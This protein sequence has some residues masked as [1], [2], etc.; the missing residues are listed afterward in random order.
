MEISGSL[1]G[2]FRVPPATTATVN[3]QWQVGQLLQATVTGSEPG[4]ALLAIGN[5]QVV[6]ETSLALQKGQQLTMLIRSLGSQPVLQITATQRESELV[7]AVRMLLPRQAGTPP[8]LASIGQLARSTSTMVPPNISELSRILLRQLPDPVSISSP[9]GLKQAL[10]ESGLFLENRLLQANGQ[11]SNPVSLNTDFKANLLRL[12]QVVRDWPGTKRDMA[13]V[14]RQATGNSNTTAGPPAAEPGKVPGNP[15]VTPEQAR[16]LMRTGVTPPATARATVTTPQNTGTPK[17]PAATNGTTV[18]S[19]TGSADRIPPPFRG[20]VPVP[21]SPVQPN[22]DLLNPDRMRT[23]FLRQ[24]EATLSRLQLQQLATVPREGE[25]SLVEWLLELPVRRGEEFDLWSMRWYQEPETPSHPASEQNGWSVQL[26][27]DLPG[28][29]PMQALV[30]LHGEQ[31]TTRFWTQ[32]ENTMPLLRA[33]LD[34]L[35]Q[36][37]RAAGLEVGKLDCHTGSLPATATAAESE[38]PLIREKA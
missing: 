33:N 6:A 8:L 1:A 21:Q 38:K 28:L 18:S 36:A 7:A 27:F 11:A 26:A 31:V 25:R 2:L 16:Q 20:T 13:P 34:E 30:Q 23:D 29:G 22:L 19:Q 24:I 4:R 37:L 3:G 12:V 14:N 9:R 35:R 17:A 5:R 10:A 15:G 32:Q